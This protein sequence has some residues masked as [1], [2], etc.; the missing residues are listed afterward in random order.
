[1]KKVRLVLVASLVSFGAI[2]T[3]SSCGD[4][5]TTCPVGYE[6]KNCDTEMRAKFVKNWSASDKTASGN[7][8]VYT[9]NVVEGSAINSVILSNTFSDAFFAH[10]INAVVDANTIKINSQKPDANGNYSVEGSGTF[11]ANEIS[12]NYYIIHDSTNVEYVHTGI[13]K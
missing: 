6:G 7:D 4:D 13:W 2:T 9:C 11:S 12:W 3:L 5:T 10:T 8:L 1:M